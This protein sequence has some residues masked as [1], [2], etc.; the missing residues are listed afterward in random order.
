MSSNS[1]TVYYNI[2]TDMNDATKNSNPLHHSD[3]DV[4]SDININ[5][6]DSV[7]IHDRII[8][9][10]SSSSTTTTTT[11]TLISK[12]LF[13]N[14][15]MFCLLFSITHATVDGVLAFA[16]AELGPEIGGDSGFSLYF[17]YTLSSLLIAKPCLTYTGPKYGVLIGLC[18]LFIYV[19]SFLFSILSP[20]IA[21][22]VF[23]T[24]SAIGG[25]G[26]GLLWTS[27]GQY[28]SLNA[29]A[30]ATASSNDL[31][32]VSVN[33]AAIFAS[34]Y[35][36]LE[37]FFQLLATA[38]F[39]YRNDEAKSSSKVEQ[40][41]T[42]VFTFYTLSAFLSIL[43][44]QF[45]VLPFGPKFGPTRYSTDNTISNSNG[46]REAF[47]T[48]NDSHVNALLINTVSDHTHT[49]STSN[50]EDTDVVGGFQHIERLSILND[51]LAVGTSIINDRRLHLLIPFQI[52]FG[53][54]SGFFGFYINASI[55]A[56]HIG[57]GYI[58][59]FIGI[60]TFSAVVLSIPY[61][62]I[63]N[64]TRYGPW[65]IMLFGALC[66]ALAGFP[67]LVASNEQISSWSFLVFYYIIHGAARGAWESTN[68]AIVTEIFL[69]EKGR[70]IA[71]AS[72]YFTSGLAGA[73]GFLFYQY[74]SRLSLAL[75]NTTVPII[76]FVS[77]AI[78]M[79]RVRST[80]SR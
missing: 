70:T 64:H 66:F 30:Y 29:A 11:T 16:T 3:S 62:R 15:I 50:T 1:N 52:S 67:L 51:V 20:N 63:S 76:S 71:F 47:V 73:F 41:K 44:F 53:L 60:A 72:V 39:V 18:C 26:A 61:A 9:S 8:L 23:V 38:V 69:S 31:S 74:M 27:Q 5:L 46:D 37:T 55:V 42:M 43:G 13:R 33:F 25:I 40:W 6:K 32:K 2:D 75:I 54:T 17:C 24:G 34:I 49:R 56:A 58:G 7:V 21:F 35:L 78:L 4:E 28:Y 57:D 59:F 10:S 77:I 65:I 80:H 45:F 19:T 12:Q 36:L 14:F 79:I 22:G 48:S 68:K